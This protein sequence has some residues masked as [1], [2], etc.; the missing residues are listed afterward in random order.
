MSGVRLLWVT[1]ANYVI[2]L[3]FGY[4]IGQSLSLFRKVASV[5]P[6]DKWGYYKP[7]VGTVR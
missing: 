5:I 3:S 2:S 6:D 1:W 4:L 7:G